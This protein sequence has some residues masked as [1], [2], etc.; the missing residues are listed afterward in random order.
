MAAGRGLVDRLEESNPLMKIK[1]S[2]NTTASLVEYFLY[3]I[4]IL[5]TGVA[6]LAYKTIAEIAQLSL[7]SRVYLVV[8]YFGVLAWVF[9][10]L[11]RL[12]RKR[13]QPQ[14]VLESV[15]QEI[16]EPATAAGPEKALEP[17]PRQTAFG[18]TGTQAMVVLLV[19]LAALKAFT[20]ALTRLPLGSR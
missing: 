5:E 12:H 1:A 13:K 3:S 18:L 16:L 9:F 2:R 6:A 15:Q 11:N 4:V 19:F 17:A 10:Q 20:W 8:L 7:A 14:K